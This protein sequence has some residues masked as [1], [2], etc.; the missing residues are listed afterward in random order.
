[1]ADGIG[2]Y[3]HGE[4]AA[5]IAIDHL[6][7]VP[8]YGATPGHV[9]A[10][11]GD[12]NAAIR[13]WAASAGVTRMGATVVAALIGPE[14]ATIAWVGDSRAY[15]YRAG[16]LEQLTRDHSVVQEL[17]EG[18]RITLAE[19]ELHPQAHV[20][21]RALGAPIPLTLHWWMALS[22]RAT[23]CSFVRTA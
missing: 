1:M 17:L 2:G 12:A 8:H 19:A 18:G 7:R 6:T 5:E 16:R 22:V 3:G 10:A 13:R 20:I 4:V 11:L 23:S 14:G 21:T 9:I 15:R